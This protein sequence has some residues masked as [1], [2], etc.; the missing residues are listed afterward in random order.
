M[1]QKAL[2]WFYYT[3]QHVVAALAFLSIR[4]FGIEASFDDVMKGRYS[5]RHFQ[6]LDLSNSQSLDD[7]LAIAR[8]CHEA[9]EKRRTLLADKCKTLLTVSSLSIALIGFVLPRLLSLGSPWMTVV[10][11]VAVVSLVNV[12]VL[13]LVLFDVGAEEYPELNQGQVGLPAADLKKSLV[14]RNLVCASSL[15]ER[16]DF[17]VDVYRTARFYFLSAFSLV[18]ILFAFS[19]FQTPKTSTAELISALRSDQALI[20]LLRGPQGSQGPPGRSFSPDDLVK[21]LHSDPILA[22]LLRGPKGERGQVDE[23]ALIEKIL[24][25]PRLSPSPTPEPLVP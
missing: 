15:D 11:V 6:N 2:D 24:A 7:L 16:T 10:F 21:R 4:L 23:K 17:H 14:N 13:L 25:D 20:G 22:Q 3:R 19:I 8:E 18:A 12:I 9:A 1:I 5:K